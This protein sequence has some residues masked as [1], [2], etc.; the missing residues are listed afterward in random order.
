MQNR[1][2]HKASDVAEA[3]HVRY[4]GARRP[5]HRNFQHDRQYRGSSRTWQD[6]TGA[7]AMDAANADDL[8]SVVDDVA[9]A[10]DRLDI[11]VNNARMPGFG[12]F[13]DEDFDEGGTKD[14][15]Y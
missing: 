9:A 5:F 11:I 14:P 7:G 6:K 13:A 12:R 3:R 2:R 15:E 1:G 8:R 4:T 10:F